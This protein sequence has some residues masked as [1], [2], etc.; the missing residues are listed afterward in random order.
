MN[1]QIINNQ[2]KNSKIVLQL[3]HNDVNTILTALSKRPFEEVFS[4]IG[5]IH[6]QSKNQLEKQIQDEK[7][8]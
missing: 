8:K 7:N 1:Q 6:T 2:T 3:N 5:E 4:L